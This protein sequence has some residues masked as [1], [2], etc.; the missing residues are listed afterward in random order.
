MTKI[1]AYIGENLLTQQTAV[2]QLAG[3]ICRLEKVVDFDVNFTFC[4]IPVGRNVKLTSKSTTFPN[5]P[6]LVN[7]VNPRPGARRL[8][9]VDDSVE[10]FTAISPILHLCCDVNSEIMTE[11]RSMWWVFWRK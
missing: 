11:N 5:V 4:A 9:N 10:C 7:D 3:V 2:L 1:R 8:R 6:S